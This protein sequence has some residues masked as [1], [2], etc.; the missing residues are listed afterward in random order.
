MDNEQSMVVLK[1]S[2]L[3]QIFCNYIHTKVRV[4]CFTYTTVDT[5]CFLRSCSVECESCD[6]PPSQRSVKEPAIGLS[7]SDLEE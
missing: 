6:P 7:D 3:T 1:F 5:P 4:T 2:P